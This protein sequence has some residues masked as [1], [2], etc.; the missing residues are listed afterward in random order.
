MGRVQSQEIRHLLRQAVLSVP[1]RIKITGIII[2][3]VL[4]LG[5]TLNFWV[6]TSLS[7]W[8]SYLLTDTRVEEA[9]RAGGR[10]VTL[11]TVLAAAGSLVM[12]SLLTYLLVQPLL[13][14]REM[15]LKVAGGQLDARAP[16][17]SNDEIGDVAIAIN[18]MTDHLV[19]SQNDLAQTNRRL[20]AINQIMLAVERE[21]EIHDALYAIL[22]I[23]IEVMNLES[24]WVYLRDPERDIFHLASWYNVPGELQA[25]L[26]QHEQTALCACQVALVDGTLQEGPGLYICQR[27]KECDRPEIPCQHIS[28]PIEA[29]GQKY[30]VV[31]LLTREE[32]ITNI[33]LLDL[34][35]AIGTQLSESVA[36]AWLR[37]KL[38]EQEL[39]RQALLE[40]LVQAQDEERV[41]LA[42][43]LHDGAGQ[44]LTSLLVRIKTLE[45]ENSIAVIKK[46]LDGLLDLTAETIEQVRDLSYRLRPVALEEFGL[47]VALRVLVEEVA[48]KAQL[49]TTCRVNLGDTTLPPGVEATLYR[50]VQEGLT[51]TVRHA[52]AS[53]VDL[54]VI[55]TEDCVNMRI[56]DDGCGFAPQGL[57]AEPGTRHLG[58]IGMRERATIASGT[59]DIYSAPGQGT[60]IVV[61]IP[62]L[63]GMPA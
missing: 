56:E 5:F 1:V 37:L 13:D 33:A 25:W 49:E 19:T 39:A 60:T 18:T 9:M 41:R 63:E 12:G 23:T 43:E 48:D 61:S 16:V 20:A 40:S 3:I 30:G 15:A 14:L 57:T 8:L 29:R 21:E 10:S 24:G 31:N 34:F 7:D 62:L 44:M 2:L 53:R 47:A 36:N 35:T 6:T 26:L 59:L 11:I 51:N 32:Q 52:S 54:E 55:A 38:R 22:R 4:I 58:L 42:R 27:I 28:L 45:K 46:G 17:W 50:I